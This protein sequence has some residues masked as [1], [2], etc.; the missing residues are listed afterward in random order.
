MVQMVQNRN[1]FFTQYKD[2]KEQLEVK[3]E[4]SFWS[5]DIEK[6]GIDL[7]KVPVSQTTLLSDKN[8]AL[9]Y[10]FPQEN[11]RLEALWDVYAYT[12]SQISAELREYGRLNLKRMNDQIGQYI[13][14][15]N[16]RLNRTL[17]LFIDLQTKL[18]TV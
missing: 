1:D 8:Q 15:F 4:T 9:K 17:S 18:V 10:M 2:K 14:S 13:E 6:W 7:A 16:S 12:N 3:K 5:K 11:S